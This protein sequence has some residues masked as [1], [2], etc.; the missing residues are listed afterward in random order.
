MQ[1]EHN[2][3]K[4][5]A[6]NLNSLLQFL[7]QFGNNSILIFY[8]IFVFYNFLFVALYFQLVLCL[9]ILV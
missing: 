5:I 4:I 7:Q 2:A 3:R 1:F 9:I 6:P 8:L